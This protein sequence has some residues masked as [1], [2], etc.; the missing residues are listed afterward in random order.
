V[1]DHFELFPEIVALGRDRIQLFCDDWCRGPQAKECGVASI[2]VAENAASIAPTLE[3]YASNFSRGDDLH[4]PFDRVAEFIIDNS[5]DEQ[6]RP[7]LK[8]R[9]QDLRRKIGVKQFQR[10]KVNLDAHAMALRCPSCSL[11][12]VTQHRIYEGQKFGGKFEPMT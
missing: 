1:P 5:C 7:A 12:M 11:V 10:Y 9:L 4:F 8:D 2:A 3:I 6:S